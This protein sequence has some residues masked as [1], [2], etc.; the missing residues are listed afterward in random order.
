MLVLSTLV[1]FVVLFTGLVYFSR[2]EQT[3]ADVI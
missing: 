2:T 1:T 3:F